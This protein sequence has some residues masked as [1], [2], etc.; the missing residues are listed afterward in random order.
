MNREE[1]SSAAQQNS[2]LIASD[3]KADNKRGDSSQRSFA[4]QRSPTGANG[5]IRQPTI[6]KRSDSQDKSSHSLAGAAATATTNAPK[7]PLMS[8]SMIQTGSGSMLSN[9][10]MTLGQQQLLNS[11]SVLERDNGHTSSSNDL[12]QV[13]EVTPR[14]MG[15][16]TYREPTNE[17]LLF[18]PSASEKKQTSSMLSDDD[19]STFEPNPR[20]SA[21]SQS[22]KK[23]GAVARQSMAALSTTA[24]KDNV[25]VVIRVRPINERERAGG[26]LAKVKQCLTVEKNEKM[27]LDRG[28]DQKTF[29][30]DY[31]AT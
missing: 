9:A 6:F 23:R 29:T 26:S 4:Y 12:T 10:A 15:T 5:G 28:M 25:K 16:L 2:N 20:T 7:P 11:N 14:A 27:I 8:A 13:Q 18:T 22:G 21:I 24:Q 1:E 3:N 31:V 19:I 30:F 17:N